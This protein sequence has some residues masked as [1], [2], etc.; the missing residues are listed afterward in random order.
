MKLGTWIKGATHNI[1]L[2][3]Y[4]VLLDLTQTLESNHKRTP[5]F[6][7]T[8]Y[9]SLNNWNQ[10]CPP[11][12]T[13]SGCILQ[14]YKSL[15]NIGLFVKKLCLQDIWTDWRTSWFLYSPQNLVCWSIMIGYISQLKNNISWTHLQIYNHR[16]HKTE[17]NIQS[18]MNTDICGC[19]TQSNTGDRCAFR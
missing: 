19:F 4:R 17:E 10:K 14:L 3:C 1:S 6:H 11:S 2:A 16:L 7:T 9:L 8:V 13:S 12:C 18:V 15:I 5:L